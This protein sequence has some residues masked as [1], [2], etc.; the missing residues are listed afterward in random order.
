MNILPTKVHPIVEK[1]EHHF[2]PTVSAILLAMT[3]AI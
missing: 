1:A 2:E 3:H